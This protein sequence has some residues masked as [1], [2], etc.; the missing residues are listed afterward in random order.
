MGRGTIY[1]CFS[2]VK[3]ECSG[4]GE[5]SGEPI[6]LRK[7]GIMQVCDVTMGMPLTKT[8]RH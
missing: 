5:V 2:L 8:S 7:E 3:A 1:G 6:H 4:A